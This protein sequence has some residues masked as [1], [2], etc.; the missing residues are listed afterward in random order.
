MVIVRVGF[1]VKEKVPA[2]TPPAASVTLRL[3][4]AVPGVVAF[5]EITLVVGAMVSPAGR[6]VAVHVY[7]GTPPEAVRVSEYETLTWAGGSGE[8]VVIATAGA[9]APVNAWNACIAGV[10]LSVAKTRY[11]YEAITVAGV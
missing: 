8:V 2:L 9:M 7:G 3:T 11:E 10:L 4:L 5:P 1:T 6:L